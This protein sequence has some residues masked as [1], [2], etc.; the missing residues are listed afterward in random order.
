MLFRS[1]FAVVNKESGAS[2]GWFLEC[3][4]T[5]IEHVIPNDGICII[6]DGHKGIKCVIREWPRGEEGREQVY[7]RYCLRHIASNFNRHFDNLTLK[8]LALKAGY[9]T[10]EAKFESIMQIIKEAEIN[11]LRGI[12][13]TDCRNERYMPYTYLVSGDMEK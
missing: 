5:S 7:H 3:L 6:S 9:V 4:R 2:W 12:D 13:F 1:A 8:A 11:L 10:H